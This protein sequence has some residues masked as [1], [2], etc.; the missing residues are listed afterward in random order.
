MNSKRAAWRKSSY[1]GGGGNC[2][3]VSDGLTIA[4]RDS[5]QPDLGH[6]EF[7]VKEWTAFLTQVKFVDL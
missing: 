5:Q 1:S 3:E 2:V 6:L 4:V 7:P